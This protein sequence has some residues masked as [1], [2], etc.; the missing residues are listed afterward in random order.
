VSLTPVEDILPGDVIRHVA[1]AAAP[2]P[3]LGVVV[4]VSIVESRV[5][6]PISERLPRRRYFDIVF[7]THSGIRTIVMTDLAMFEKIED[8]LTSD[9]LTY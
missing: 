9:E 2:Y 6:A 3:R 5:G 8:D 4:I 7:L 1:E